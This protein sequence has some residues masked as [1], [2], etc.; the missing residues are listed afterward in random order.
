LKSFL[1]I[2]ADELLGKHKEKLAGICIV[3]PSRRA[4]IHF[5]RTIAQKL[6]KPVWSPKITGI[7]DFVAMHSPWAVADDL[8]LVFELFECYKA[9]SQE[10]SFDKFYPWGNMML[11]DFDEIDR[12]LVEADYLFRVLAEHKEVEERF[13]F[14]AAESEEFTR[15]WKSFSNKEL[16]GQQKDF[17]NTWEVMGKVYHSFRRRLMEKGICYEGM[18]YRKIYEMVKI[19]RPPSASP[20]EGGRLIFNYDKV[21]FAGFNQLNRAEELIFKDLFR[22]GKAEIYW[23]TD[24]YYINNDM[25]E[26]GKFLRQNFANLG[27]ENKLWIEQNLKNSVKE[28]TITGS[29][30]E[31]GQSK[32]LGYF[33]GKSDHVKKDE[34]EKTVIVLPDESMLMPVLHSIPGEIKDINVTM[35]Y[36]FKNSSLYNLLNSLKNLHTNKKGTEKNPVYYHKDCIDILSNPLVSSHISY[37]NA[38]VEINRRS[39]IYITAGRILSF[40]GNDKIAEIIFHNIISP[41]GLIKYLLEIISVLSE[42]NISVFE[43]EFFIKLWEKL[44]QINTLVLKYSNETEVLTVWRIIIDVMSS[45]KIPFTGEPLK[46]LQ[47][48]GL[49]ETRSLDFDNVYILSMNEGTV[50]RGKTGSSYIP[51]RLRRAFRMPTYED[52]DAAFAYYFYRLLQRAKNVHLL[53]NTESVDLISGEKSRFILQVENELPFYN[54]KIRLNNNIFQADIDEEKNKDIIIQKSGAIIQKLNDRKYSASA[55]SD[56]IACSLKFYFSKIAGL[57]KEEIAEETFSGASFGSL[58][59]E[60]MSQLYAGHKNKLLSSEDIKTV[61]K[62][63]DENF[64]KVWENA[65][66]KIEELKEFGKEIYGKN[67][68]FKNVIKKLSGLILENDERETPFKILDI[69]GNIESQIEIDD[70]THSINLSGR[71][72]RVEE[73]NGITR[74]ID[75]KTGTFSPKNQK[76]TTTDEYFEKVF[77]DTDYRESFQQYFYAMLYLENYPASKMNIGIYPL[78]STGSGIVFYEDEDSYIPPEKISLFRDKLNKLFTEIFNPGIPFKKTDDIEICKFCDYKSICYRE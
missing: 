16:T 75:Y 17:I 22:S 37:R 69:E 39:I 52:E 72:D 30:L 47:V 43:K 9:E 76:N 19:N 46:G 34:I 29:V 2:L 31:S 42:D 51:Y 63:L 25:M 59:H 70:N 41:A 5:K 7:Q 77:S 27:D 4:C 71:L 26:A 24:E 10:E 57:K 12:N 14:S 20:T 13:G 6:S 54:N 32:A 1:E 45:V 35:G 78:R 58:L 8:E 11:S 21:I 66:T 56:Y 68:L 23:D 64:D 50:P 38:I 33:L 55:L 49:L 18:A 3:F 36:P 15:F 65:C 60:I 28:I 67:L 40:T 74:I 53:Y 73:K 48:M 62:H 44:K 61:R